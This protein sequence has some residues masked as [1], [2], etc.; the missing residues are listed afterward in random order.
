MLSK[1]Q[2]EFRKNGIGGSDVAAIFGLSK[3][4]TPVD[5]YLDKIGEAPE[6]KESEWQYMGKK[7]ESIIADVFEEKT[8]KEVCHPIGTF[9]HPEKTFMIANVDRQVVGESA[10]LECKNSM[11][12]QG[13]GEQGTDEIPDEYL[14]QVAH[15]AIV[16][17]VERAYIAVLISGN[18]FRTYVYERNKKLEDTIIA[19]EE[20][21]WNEHVLK[22][23]PPSIS[24]SEDA[25]KLYVNS[26][27]SSL[28]ANA[29]LKEFISDI[30]ETKQKI[31]S[32][33]DY[34]EKLKTC[35]FKEMQFNES[36]SDEFGNLLAVWKQQKMTRFD[37]DLFKKE[38]P[39]LYKKYC[40]TS[41][42]RKFLLK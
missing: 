32:L 37:T 22:R 29:T 35:I 39:E 34:E 41:S 1:E 3:W 26:V 16:K 9:V 8:G 14:L 13:W 21:F 5:I 24:S 30:K 42:F 25:K 2:M 10:I 19:Q 11:F 31:K 12:S 17:N 20:K 4:R 27:F 28:T 15:Y 6:R 23:I 40:K 7:I 38:H 36:L 18:T 33:E